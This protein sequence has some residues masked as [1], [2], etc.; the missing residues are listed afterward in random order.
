MSSFK[1]QKVLLPFILLAL[2]SCGGGNTS[3]LLD[4]SSSED[5]PIS[6]SISTSETQPLSYKIEITKTLK[7][8]NKK[9]CPSL[10]K[11]KALIVPVHFSNDTTSMNVDLIKGAFDTPA[12]SSYVPE[13][14]DVKS[15]Y[16]ESSYGKLDFEFIFADTYIPSNPSTY[17]ESKA[18]FNG[19]SYNTNASRAL[20]KEILEHYDNVYDYSDFDADKDG[21]IDCIYMIYDH[22]VDYE[23]KNMFWWAYTSWYIDDDKFDNVGLGNYIW[24]GLDFFTKDGLTN[25]TQTIIHET[26]HLFGVDDYYDYDTTKGSTKGGLGGADLMDNDKG[27]PCGEHNAYTKSLLGWITPTVIDLDE[28]NKELTLDLKSF[29]ETG[30]TIILANTF[31]KDKEMYQ[32]YFMLEYY[33]P[34]HLSERD[35]PFT[36]PG[37]RVLHVASQLDSKGGIKYNN[38]STTFKLISQINTKNGDT[39]INNNAT[40]NDST[41]FTIGESLDYVEYNNEKPLKYKFEVISLES[42]KCTI[43]FILK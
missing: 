37:V 30:E 25:N 4:S 8:I 43:K 29:Q 16:K 31:D 22:P 1:K 28:S 34:T 27:S 21:I 9:A 14:R 11:V 15:F 38:T 6:S 10:G 36:L 24:C 35:K 40:R 7:T 3:S 20:Y 23:Y 19:D 32:E 18:N 33:T 5:L 41:L 13:W 39:Y 12:N 26:A 17:Y 2:V 42:S